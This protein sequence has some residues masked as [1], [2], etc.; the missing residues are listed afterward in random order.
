MVV[1]EER[2]GHQSSKGVMSFLLIN[3]PSVPDLRQGEVPVTDWL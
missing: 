1:H 2:Q 3:H